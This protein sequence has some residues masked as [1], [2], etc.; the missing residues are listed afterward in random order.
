M[1]TNITNSSATNGNISKAPTSNPGQS[2]FYRGIEA[3]E[4]PIYLNFSHPGMKEE[5]INIL[6][7]R[8]DDAS[9]KRVLTFTATEPMVVGIGHRLPVDKDIL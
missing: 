8:D 7:Y 2:I 4:E 3:S 9:Y 5:T 1:T 6:P